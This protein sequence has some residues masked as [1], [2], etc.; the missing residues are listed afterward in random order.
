[1]NPIYGLTNYLNSGYYGTQ[2]PTGATLENEGM[3]NYNADQ[4]ASTIQAQ[5]ANDQLSLASH[6]MGPLPDRSWEGW[7]Q[8]LQDASPDGTIHLGGGRSPAGSSQ[9]TGRGQQPPGSIANDPNSSF[10]TNPTFG[11]SALRGLQSYPGVGGGW[12]Y[13]STVPYHYGDF[14]ASRVGLNG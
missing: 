5:R 13:G 9:L 2:D 4:L 1:M 14:T 3:A 12:T 8:A 7:Y 6:M 11:Q 10:N